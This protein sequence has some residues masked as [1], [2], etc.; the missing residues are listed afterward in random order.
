MMSHWP[1]C[2]CSG[3]AVLSTKPLSVGQH[4][5]Y[6]LYSPCGVFISAVVDEGWRE[7]C[8]SAAMCFGDAGGIF[9]YPPD[10]EDEV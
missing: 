1:W 7:V 5:V 10:T 9:K 6:R 2:Q 3:E 8:L 4:P